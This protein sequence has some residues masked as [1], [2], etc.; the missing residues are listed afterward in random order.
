MASI[1]VAGLVNPLTG[2]PTVAPLA[3]LVDHVGGLANHLRRNSDE[4][5]VTSE[6][7]IEFTGT[8]ATVIASAAEHPVTAA[9]RPFGP[10]GTTSVSI[11]ELTCGRVPVATATVPSFHIRAPEH[12]MRRPLD[13]GD[14]DAAGVPPTL[15]ARLAVE[16]A[17]AAV[18]DGRVG[19]PL[20]TASLRVNCLRQFQAGGESRYEGTALRAG[21][22]SGVAD[23]KAVGA[24]G[25]VALLARLTAYP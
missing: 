25:E 11:C 16:V 15:A 20:Q 8:A 17:S 23:A 12:L 1:P 9:A 6:L 3:M 18:N 19:R 10:K 14:I 22:S 5:T 4:W 2:A 24:D 13:S 7:A 21:R